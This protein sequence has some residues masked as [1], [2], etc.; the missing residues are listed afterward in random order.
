MQRIKRVKECSVKGVV[1]LGSVVRA[2]AEGASTPSITVPVSGIL[3]L[4]CH[5]RNAL[6]AFFLPTN[7]S[8]TSRLCW[9]FL[10]VIFLDLEA[11]RDVSLLGTSVAFY[12]S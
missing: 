10:Q 5:Q 7:P 12:F 6:W 1:G 3:L 9:H 11:K 8:S 4:P 2:C